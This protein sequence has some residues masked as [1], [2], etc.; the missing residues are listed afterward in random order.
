MA[1]DAKHG[2]NLDKVAALTSGATCRCA[3]RRRSLA[4]MMRESRMRAGLAGFLACGLA[5]C[6]SAPAAEMDRAGFVDAARTVSGLVVDM[7]YFGEENFV[8][9]RISGYAAPVCL[10][11]RE[12]AEALGKAQALVRASGFG[13][14][15]YDCYRPTRAV[16][17]FAA[18]ARDPA[19]QKRKAEHYPAIDKSRLFEL[20][21][22]AERSGHSRGSTVDVTLVHLGSMLEVDMGSPYDLFDPK[23]WPTDTTVSHGAIVNRS[24]L[25][26]AM[27]S[28][29]FR[30]LTEEWWHFTLNDEPHPETYFDFLVE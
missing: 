13:L 2:R 5:A 21:Y 4:G 10:L 18:W 1:G 30:P 23:S 17:D 29:G 22:I 24:L 8:G 11:T 28:A 16:A 20:G 3:R 9:R 26:G 6:A 12:A 7:R 14:K 19:D 27:I 25:Q 15:V